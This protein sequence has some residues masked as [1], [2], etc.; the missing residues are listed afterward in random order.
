M[1]TTH[2]P[3]NPAAKKRA[4]RKQFKPI[5]ANTAALLSHIARRRKPI[6]EAQLRTAGLPSMHP[7]AMNTL[8]R[9]G[10]L[11]ETRIAA[12][13]TEPKASAYTITPKGRE[14]LKLRRE[15]L[16]KRLV[17]ATTPKAQAKSESETESE[18]ATEGDGNPK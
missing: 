3:A 18:A 17:E 1:N 13:A 6:T 9:N 16:S 4:P 11:I 10:F 12:T 2:T 7:S 8:V 15:W 14:S 5:E